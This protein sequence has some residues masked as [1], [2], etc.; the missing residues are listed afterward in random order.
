[1]K[2]LKRIILKVL[3]WVNKENTDNIFK[4]LKPIRKY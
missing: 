1:M 2:Y 4:K 3:E